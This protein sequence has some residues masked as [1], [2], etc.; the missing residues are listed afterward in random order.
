MW[1]V[2]AAIAIAVVWFFSSVGQSDYRAFVED[3]LSANIAEQFNLEITADCP[4][5]SAKAGSVF[6]CT[7]SQPFDAFWLMDVDSAKVTVLNSSGDIEWQW[8]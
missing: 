6:V 7:L 1:T 5:A 2:A 8:Y 4:S 3:A